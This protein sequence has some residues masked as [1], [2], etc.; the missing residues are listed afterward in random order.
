MRSAIWSTFETV[1]NADATFQAPALASMFLTLGILLPFVAI[2]D[3][4]GL[5]C[6]FF[7]LQTEHPS[8]RGGSSVNFDRKSIQWLEKLKELT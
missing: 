4:V 6:L 7:G 8:R 2:S 5:L 3:S 1:F